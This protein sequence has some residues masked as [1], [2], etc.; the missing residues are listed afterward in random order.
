[1]QLSGTD[2]GVIYVYDELEQAFHLR[3]SYGLRKDL[4]AAIEN[5]YLGA[6]DAIREATRAQKP[7][8]VADI[9]DEPP[10]PVREI[11]MRSG[12]TPAWS[13]RWSTRRQGSSARW[14]SGAGGRESFPEIPSTCCRPLPPSRCWRSR[15]RACFA[16]SKTRAAS[17]RSPAGTSR[18][19][20]PA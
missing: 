1:V 15:M 13:C 7:V 11:A 10:S 8:Q 4:I 16:R 3:A 5:Q 18:S 17:S 20:S 2:S 9:R 6:S 14:W 19:S 12:S